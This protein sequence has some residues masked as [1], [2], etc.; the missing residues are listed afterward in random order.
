MT[1]V[2]G[3]VVKHPLRLFLIVETLAKTVQKGPSHHLT[4]KSIFA[5]EVPER[6][7]GVGRQGYVKSRNTVTQ[8]ICH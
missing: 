7:V 4:L 1:N 6:I 8:I 3:H 5:M 2:P